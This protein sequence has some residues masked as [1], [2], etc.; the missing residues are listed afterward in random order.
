MGNVIYPLWADCPALSRGLVVGYPIVSILLMIIA[1]T[2]DTGLS[3]TEAMFFCSLD[4]IKRLRLWTLAIGPFF[5]PVTNG[6]GFLM[7]LFEMY[8][9]MAYFPHREKELGSTIFIYWMFLMNLLVNLVYLAAMVLLYMVF[10]Q[11]SYLSNSVHG[12]WPLVMLCLTLRLMGDPNGSTSF[13]GLVMIPNKWFPLCLVG[14]FMLL[15]GLTIQW[16]LIAALAIGYGYPYL[17]I[18]ALLLSPQRASRLESRCCGG[19]QCTILSSSW[20]P[21]L[22]S[23]YDAEPDSRYANLSGFGQRSQEMVVDNRAQPSSD[24]GVANNF[25]AFSGAGTRLGDGSAD[26]GDSFV[27]LAAGAPA[28]EA[29][30]P[31]AQPHAQPPSPQSQRHSTDASAAA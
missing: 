2:S 22:R 27:P 19:G 7:I 20:I 31:A 24:G 12:L 10:K 29:Q 28:Q 8:M 4:N 3:V 30:H 15:G 14:F 6:F 9:V 16:E 18:K 26:T 23:S 21:A 11:P 1:N 17:P 13:W 5:K 25:Q